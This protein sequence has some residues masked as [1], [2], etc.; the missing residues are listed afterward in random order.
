MLPSVTTSSPFT[1][2]MTTISDFRQ[3]LNDNTVK[4][5]GY[6]D[7]IDLDPEGHAKS[8]LHGGILRDNKDTPN[9]KLQQQV[10]CCLEFLGV[11]CFLFL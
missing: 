2:L 8:V 3:A 6:N 5:K 9:T 10:N 1:L 11:F 7:R 4:I